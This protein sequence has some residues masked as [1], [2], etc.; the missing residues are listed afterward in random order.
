MVMVKTD[1]SVRK[2]N[3]GYCLVHQHHT[4]TLLELRAGGEGESASKQAIK[5]G[6]AG[7]CRCL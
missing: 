3:I 7:G 6:E 1:R 5:H 4:F 2:D